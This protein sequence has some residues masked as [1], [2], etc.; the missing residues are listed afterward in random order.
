[1]VAHVAAVLLVVQALLGALVIGASASAGPTLDAF[2]NP[3]CIGDSASGQN[4]QS[5]HPNKLDCCT[6]SCNLFAFAAF[7][8]D[9]KHALSNPRVARGEALRPPLY[10]HDG[11]HLPLH[12]AG[13]PRAPPSITI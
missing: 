2:G 8:S 6:T 11:S 4:H 5:K 9:S 13:A 12:G 3:L 10:I 7:G 1:M